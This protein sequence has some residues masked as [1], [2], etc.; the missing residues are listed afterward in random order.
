M[1]DWQI[2]RQQERLYFK[3]H[4]EIKVFLQLTGGTW[5]ILVKG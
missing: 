1:I 4:V 3:V 5:E 2:Q